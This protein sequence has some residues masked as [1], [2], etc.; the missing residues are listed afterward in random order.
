MFCDDDIAF[1]RE[2]FLRQLRRLDYGEVR[3]LEDY[4]AGYVLTRFLAIHR[5]DFARVGGFDTRLNHME[6]TDF[7]MQV[8]RTGLDLTPLSRDDVTHYEHE[9]DVTTLTR[10]KSM[11]FL[12]FKHRHRF[13]PVAKKILS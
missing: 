4:G 9:N 8:E 3:G 6:D 11:A 1:D 12:T 10:A 13:L 7:G 5:V 2:W